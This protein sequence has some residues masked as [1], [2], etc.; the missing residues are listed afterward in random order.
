MIIVQ[1][2]KFRLE[3]LK[4]FNSISGIKNLEVIINS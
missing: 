2:Q 4:K 3:N 1:S